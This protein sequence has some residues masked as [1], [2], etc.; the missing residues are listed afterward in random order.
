MNPAASPPAALARELIARFGPHPATQLGLHLGD[1][2]DETLGR[3]LVG[4]CLADPRLGPERLRSGLRALAA[5]GVAAPRTIAAAEPATLAAALAG[6][7]YPKPEVAAVVLWRASSALVEDHDGSVARLAGAAEG[8]ED[9]AGR[10]ARLAPGVGRATVIRFLQPLRGTWPAADEL[11]LDTAALAAAVHL[12][13]LRDGTDEESAPATLRTAL[14]AESPP[15][16]DVEAA[17]GRLGRRS[18]VRGRPDR[19]PLGADCPLS[20]Q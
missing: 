20:E 10:V 6:A 5:A 12:G 8:L 7:D 17:L 9:L 13:W 16:H 14:G 1:P 3:W 11:P 2:D 4:A 15:L 19:C 18:C